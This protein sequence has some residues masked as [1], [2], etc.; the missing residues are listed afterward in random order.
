MRYAITVGLVVLLSFCVLGVNSDSQCAL[1]DLTNASSVEPLVV[2]P[3]T[4]AAALAFSEDGSILTTLD[5]ALVL[6]DWDAE[7][8]ELVSEIELDSV[9]PGF[10]RSAFSPDGA[11][12]A[13]S[14]PDHAVAVWRRSDGVRTSTLP[15][16]AFVMGVQFSPDS[17]ILAV[18][19][20]DGTVEFWH[21]LTGELLHSWSAHPS[22]SHALAF[23]PDMTIFASGSIN[24]TWTLRVWQ[25]VNWELQYERTDHQ[26]DVYQ[27]LFVR[28]GA[29]FLSVSGDRTIMLWDTASGDRIRTYS[30]HLDIVNDV[31][32]S[33]AGDILATAGSDRR[34]MLWNF[35]TATVLATLTGHTSYVFPI[36][37]SPLGNRLA[38]GTSS[39][40]GEVILWGLP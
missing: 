21:P 32:I 18:G 40:S 24:S 1:I 31:A 16:N 13:A 30:G 7:T 3:H 20:F 8:G 33:P 22:A 23:S 34:V 27:I 35:E 9:Q 15:G 12:V 11:L 5:G 25:M 39:G 28:E 4:W 6:R 10:R 38:S 19:R 36:A 37:Y 26:E 14:L 2:L 17:S 29:Q